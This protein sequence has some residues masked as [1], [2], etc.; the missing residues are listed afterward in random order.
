MNRA[1]RT[2]S[3]LTR[4]VLVA[5]ALALAAACKNNSTT[6]PSTPT[7]TLTTETFT[8]SVPTGGSDIHN[9]NVAQTGAVNVTLTA[10]GPPATIYMGLGVGT[11]SGS[12]CTLLPEVPPTC[13]PPRR[14]SSPASARPARSA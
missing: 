9:F 8:G 14:L 5:L 1:V 11:P 10:A 7:V 3:H 12:D 4:L 13:R 2:P 6:T